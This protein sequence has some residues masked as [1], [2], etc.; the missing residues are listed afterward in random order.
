MWWGDFQQHVLQ[1]IEHDAGDTLG[2]GGKF[3]QICDARH[4]QLRAFATDRH[5]R[6]LCLGQRQ[7]A[8]PVDLLDDNDLSRLQVGNQPQQLGPVGASPRRLFAVYT[9]DIIAARPLSMMLS[10]C[11]RS[12]SSV[13]TRR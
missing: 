3:R 13:L 7:A 5:H 2:I 6:L 1:G 11:S 9:R 4:G 12:Y 8:D 10:C